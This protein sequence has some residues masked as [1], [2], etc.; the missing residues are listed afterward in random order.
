MIDLRDLYPCCVI[1]IKARAVIQGN[2]AQGFDRVAIC[3]TEF[4]D[5]DREVGLNFGVSVDERRPHMRI[6]LS[7]PAL[8][9]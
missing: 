7:C 1:K 4:G 9:D 6:L 5:T 8:C 3:R 2:A